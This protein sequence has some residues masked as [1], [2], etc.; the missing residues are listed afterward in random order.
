MLR[1]SLTPFSVMTGRG[2]RNEISEDGAEVGEESR[3]ISE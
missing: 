1:R 3:E 2:R